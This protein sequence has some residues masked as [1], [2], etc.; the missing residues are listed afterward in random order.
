M[1]QVSSL[2]SGVRLLT[3]PR[4]SAQ[5]PG[6]NRSQ[7]WMSLLALLGIGSTFAVFLSMFTLQVNYS[8]LIGGMLLCWLVSSV[9]CTLGRRWVLGL[10]PAVIGGELLLVKYWSLAVDGFCYMFNSIYQCVHHTT[11]LH[12]TGLTNQNE[13]QATTALL[14]FCMLFLG[15][16][17]CFFTI[18][19]PNAVICFVL[20]FAL[21]EIGLYYGVAPS[22]PAFACLLAY[23]VGILAQDRAYSP[24]H[25]QSR[26][27]HQYHAKEPL[28]RQVAIQ[29]A[30]I[31]LVMVLLL[32]TAVCAGLKLS[33]FSRSQQLDQWRMQIKTG[34]KNITLPNE[35]EFH[36]T[37]AS[38]FRFS[39]ENRT[40]DTFLLGRQNEIRFSYQPMLQLEYG[41]MPE[42]NMYLKSYVG[43]RYE[44]NSWSSL[45]KAQ[46]EILETDIQ[47]EDRDLGQRLLTQ[48][49]Q[50]W[51]M[52]LEEN[53]GIENG[54]Y[55]D[56][57]MISQTQQESKTAY[58]PY[59]VFILNDPYRLKPYHDG[60][61]RLYHAG[62]YHL[63]YLTT[64]YLN[65]SNLLV[66]ARYMD[67]HPE[68][69][70]NKESRYRKFVYD[71]YLYVP[72]TEAMHRVQEAYRDR[73]GNSIGTS[74]S[75][76]EHVDTVLRK[77]NEIYAAVTEDSSYTL[78]PGAVP[79]NRDL[80]EYFLLESRKGYC[81]YFA[82]A[83]VMLCRMAGIPARYVEGVAV[84]KEEFEQGETV[85]RSDG[86]ARNR[87]T[88]DDC[89]AHSWAE[90]YLDG[91]GWIPYDFTPGGADSN[92]QAA[93]QTTSATSTSQTHTTITVTTAAPEHTQTSAANTQT[94]QRSDAASGTSASFRWV[95]LILTILAL[96]ILL[97]L[98]ILQY[99]KRRAERIWT[100]RKAACA[101]KDTNAAVIVAYQYLLLLLKEAG[102]TPAGETPG[103]FALRAEAECP[104]LSAHTLTRAAGI[105][106]CADLSQH[107]VSEE[108]R[109]FVTALAMELQ[110]AVASDCTGFRRFRLRF[111][112]CLIQ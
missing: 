7:V 39:D 105:A 64:D 66:I 103:G 60:T 29:T 26:H 30:L 79:E 75:Y 80:V 104:F 91:I 57:M 81:S 78:T 111:I 31:G 56:E 25:L 37:V 10:I 94:S 13:M 55:I 28:R 22:Y 107:T 89:H 65:P 15:A 18:S 90:I 48:S 20:T 38:P 34:M 9:L 83:G 63:I 19:R 73:L 53:Y 101:S 72:D 68:V 50:Y 33:H 74:E 92:Q 1:K 76:A 8:L 41:R 6:K 43:S 88:V 17:I 47:P 108:D 51:S 71:S 54:I 35:L 77:L 70:E 32:F 100:K 45:T 86:T 97:P 99:L 112:R 95:L 84:S 87:L 62:D 36:T 85:Y 106:E 58:V 16:L 110:K 4:M 52:S 67:N 59:P 96:V 5:A 23:W 24:L 46:Y 109:R 98:G 102:I 44:S 21:P 40:T 3:A 82:T 61:Y 2:D 93:S 12:Y 49:I 27:S 69:Q 11:E 14:L 42:Y